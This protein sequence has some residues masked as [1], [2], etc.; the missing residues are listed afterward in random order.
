MSV[1]HTI[2]NHQSSY[3]NGSGDAWNGIKFLGI[4]SALTES[5]RERDVI[6]KDSKFPVIPVKTSLKTTTGTLERVFCKENIP[7]LMA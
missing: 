1:K 6:L 2:Q 7:Y 4:W 5:T 3:Q